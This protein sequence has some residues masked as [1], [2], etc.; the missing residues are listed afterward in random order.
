MSLSKTVADWVEEED[1]LLYLQFSNSENVLAGNVD[2]GRHLVGTVTTRVITLLNISSDARFCF[3]SE[4]SWYSM[5]MVGSLD[6]IQYKSIV[7]S[8]VTIFK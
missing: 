6:Y 5:N 3:M 4:E 7:I 8:E 2:C 1:I